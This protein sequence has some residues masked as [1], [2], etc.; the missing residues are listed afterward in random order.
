ML[1]ANQFTD[2]S[3][4]DLAFDMN[5]HFL[6]GTTLSATFLMHPAIVSLQSSLCAV[7]S[8][9]REARVD[10]YDGSLILAPFIVLESVRHLMHQMY[11]SRMI[12]AT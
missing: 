4:M 12:V 6:D 8:V 10:A 9:A 7:A 5:P 11:L 3:M 2:P 1:A